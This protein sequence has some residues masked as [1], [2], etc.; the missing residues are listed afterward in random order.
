MTDDHDLGYL[1]W[2]D[3]IPEE[4]FTDL[5]LRIV[6]ACLVQ[7]E[8]HP[9]REV[10]KYEVTKDGDK[11]F[12]GLPRIIHVGLFITPT[13]SRLGKL[14]LEEIEKVQRGE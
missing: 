7:D 2:A 13:T 9:E 14:L 3:A 4:E 11:E 8:Q 12:Q 1:G 10:V 5:D 6:G